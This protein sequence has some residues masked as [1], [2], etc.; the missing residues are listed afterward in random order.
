MLSTPASM[1][2]RLARGCDRSVSQA[3]MG[4]GLDAPRRPRQLR[5]VDRP[6]ASRARD[7]R[8]PIVSRIRT[9]GIDRG[10]F[11][12]VLPLLLEFSP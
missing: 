6:I 12:H 5:G 11:G 9:A 4:G 2:N 10:V 7:R 3:C 8:P 1:L